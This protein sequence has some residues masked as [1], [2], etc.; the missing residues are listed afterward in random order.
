MQSGVE[1]AAAGTAQA[2][3]IKTKAGADLRRNLAL[4]IT[5][6]PPVLVDHTLQDAGFDT[7]VKLEAI[8]ADETLLDKLVELLQK[9]VVTIDEITSSQKC[10]GYIFAKRRDTASL[11]DTDD[12]DKDRRENLLYEDFHPFIPRKL[13]NDTAMKVLEFDGY[14]RTVDEFFSSLEGQKLES[15]LNEREATARRKLEAARDDQAKRIEGL[16]EAQSLNM[17]KAA[18]IEA[19]A[20]RIQE[21]MDAVNGLLAQG[22]DWVDTEK[23]IEREQKRQNPVAQIIK[24]P[25][26]LAESTIT[27]MLAEE[28]EEPLEEDD[29]FETDEEDSDDDGSAPQV[30]P[31]PVQQGLAIDINLTMTPWANAREYYTQRRTAVVKE[32][33]TQQ[34]AAKA[35]KSTEQKIAEDLKKGLKQEKALLQP[36]RKQMWF[37]KFTWFISSDGYLVLG[38]KDLQQGEILYRRHLKKGDVYCHA[39]LPGAASVVIKNNPNTP[40]APIPPQTLAQAGNLSVCSSSAWD[41]KAGMGAWWVNADQVSKTGPGGDFLSPGNFVVRDKKN[42]LPPAQLL[43]GLALM[44]RVSEESKG[45]HVKHRLYEDVPQSQPAPA[46]T[47]VQDS[48]KVLSSDEEAMAEDHETADEEQD[49]EPD[50]GPRANPLQRLDDQPDNDSDDDEATGDVTG[51][52]SQLQVSQEAGSEASIPAA[53]GAQRVDEVADAQEEESQSD[54]E[55]VGGISKAATKTPSE[56]GTGTTT[57]S[58]HTAGP[59]RRRRKKV[60]K[61]ATKYKDQDEEDRAAAEAL[62][63]AKTGQKKAEEEAKLKAAREAELAAAKE[64]RRAQHQRQQKETAAH[65]EARRARMNEAFDTIDAEEA[66]Q[67]TSFDDLV[68]TP[69]HGDEILEVIPICAPWSALVKCKYKVKLQPGAMKKGKAVKEILERWKVASGKKGV[70]DE[71]ARDSERMWPREVELI[72][73]LKAEEFINIVPVGKVRVMTAGGSASGGG[74]KGGGGKGQGKGGRGGKGSKRS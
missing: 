22:M 35:L 57:P 58:Q 68:G 48:S 74:G 8:L 36:I 47:D 43:L 45:K 70:L 41:S 18:A 73:G 72:K 9:A 44:F 1:K 67:L 49:D 4:N 31:K 38:G 60:K 54:A 14:N 55:S 50:E 51:K 71:L 23:L 56:A 66:E 59:S 34:Q 12:V 29:P 10:K 53:Q 27:L 62:I 65:E 21:A 30:K 64:R 61:I 32:E 40:D 13:A 28:E 39:D 17:R 63:G 46:S 3:K 52:V 19:N 42:F 69:L 37:E 33:K 11:A 26:K 20:E 15:R 25:L 6:L 16:Q 2:K 7:T 5:E 24:T